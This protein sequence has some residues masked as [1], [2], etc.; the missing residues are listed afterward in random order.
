MTSGSVPAMVAQHATLASLCIGRTANP[1]LTE[2]TSRHT[3]I[4]WFH[5]EAAHIGRR[6][7]PMC[8]ERGC[9]CTH[10]HTHNMM[11][12]LLLLASL[13]HHSC[14]SYSPS[15][16]YEAMLLSAAA[17]S[18][19]PQ[20]CLT[21]LQAPFI[22]KN[23]TDVKCDI[24]G[25]HCAA[26]AAVSDAN[27]LV[28]LSFRGTNSDVQLL[29]EALEEIGDASK[30]FVVGK[31]A[32][33]WYKGFT[34]LQPV[35]QTGLDLAKKYPSYQVLVTGHSLGGALASLTSTYLAHSGIKNTFYAFG[36]PRVGNTAY[37]SGHDTL[38]DESYRVVHYCDIVTHLPTCDD[39]HP[40]PYPVSSC[41]PD[42]TKG[43]YH[44]GLEIF[45]NMTD[46]GQSSPFTEC[47][48]QPTNEDVT[49][50]CS[51]YISDRS[52]TCVALHGISDHTHY[53]GIDLGSF[54]E[55]NC[56]KSRLADWKFSF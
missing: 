20:T 25:S 19:D 34:A 45:Y 17:Y 30:D 3:K 12:L 27:Q 15:S 18:S 32:D 43:Y 10:T 9:S 48:G 41:D 47:R 49:S 37:A 7:G 14:G 11:L 22:V 39:A 40:S 29:M 36:L 2:S 13:S 21:N 44:H 5:S 54:G 46:M 8:L 35:V 26:Y 6:F 38:V 23:F 51:D 4:S 28:L 53:F 42:N 52:P 50:K 56:Q 55:G 31:V 1:S 33:Y 16:A 24:A